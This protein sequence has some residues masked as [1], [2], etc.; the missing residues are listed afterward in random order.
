MKNKTLE[1]LKNLYNRNEN[2]DY[3]IEV[4]LDK[5]ANAFNEWD[6][7]YL[8]VRDLN[9]GLVYF[10]ERCSKDIP[11]RE[12]V[13]LKFIMHAAPDQSHE[14]LLKKA[15]KANFNYQFLSEKEELKQ[16]YVKILKYFVISMIFLLS[17]FYLKPTMQY[18]IIS[19]TLIEGLFI[20]GW[21]FLW[22]A[23]SLFSFEKTGIVNKLKTYKRLLDAGIVFEYHE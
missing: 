10:L 14:N 1:Y 20:G 8:E 21:V 15:L 7:A 2:G 13:E 3:Q 16:L 9:P 18:H 19:T 11:F 4:F 23:I 12:N 17:T 5:Y 22:Q 6:S